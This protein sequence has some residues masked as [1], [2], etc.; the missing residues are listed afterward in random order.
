[1]YV[2]VRVCARACAYIRSINQSNPPTQCTQQS[3]Q[4][5]S[6]ALAT[7]ASDDG[8][9]TNPLHNLLHARTPIP[10]D[11]ETAPLVAACRRPLLSLTSINDTG[12]AIAAA[13]AAYQ[14]A[15]SHPTL[16]GQWVDGWRE[17]GEVLWLWGKGKA[18][19]RCLEMV[20]E[21]FGVGRLGPATTVRNGLG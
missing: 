9:T 4:A 16:G 8:T 13:S 11:E 1:M 5:L 18:A 6:H 2:Y 14:Q 20:I 17:W 19:R 12:S 10:H 21:R 7:W 3:E 15:L